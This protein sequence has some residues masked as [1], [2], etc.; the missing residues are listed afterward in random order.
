MRE[1]KTFVQEH[2]WRIAVTALGL[3]AIALLQPPTDTDTILDQCMDQAVQEYSSGIS[4]VRA[5]DVTQCYEEMRDNSASQ[6]TIYPSEAE[7][8]Q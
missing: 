6:L 2:D 4:H 8:T 1:I 3:T 7:D 5:G